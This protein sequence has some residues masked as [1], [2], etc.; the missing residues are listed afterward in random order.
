[1]IFARAKYSKSTAKLSLELKNPNPQGPAGAA[2]MPHPR[3]SRIARRD[4]G[5]P[6][7][8]GRDQASPRPP[9]ADPPALRRASEAR[10]LTM[11]LRQ[12]YRFSGRVG[13]APNVQCRREI[14]RGAT[15]P[16]PPRSQIMMDSQ[17]AAFP[18]FTEHHVQ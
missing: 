4:P 9:K 6:V 18:A 10:D 17:D 13:Y 11:R 1:M 16:P 14:Q 8:S 2:R 5:S 3:A 7:L 12:F 15:V